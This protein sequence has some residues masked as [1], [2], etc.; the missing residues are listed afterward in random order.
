[1]S[2]DMNHSS[3]RNLKRKNPE[4][5]SNQAT[6]SPQASQNIKLWGNNA[7]GI[8]QGSGGQLETF[9][10]HFAR[11]KLYEKLCP[12]YAR[13]KD[14]KPKTHAQG[15]RIANLCYDVLTIVQGRKWWYFDNSP[16]ATSLV[17]EDPSDI[18]KMAI[19]KIKQGLR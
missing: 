19:G 8:Y 17:L 5:P 6:S 2:N 15:D 13:S 11:T 9:D 12:L 3:E 7:K 18:K 14:G 4:F 10:G 1:M 16:G